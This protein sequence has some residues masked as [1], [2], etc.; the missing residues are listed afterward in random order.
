MCAADPTGRGI[1]QENDMSSSDEE[2]FEQ[3]G[4]A[5]HAAVSEAVRPWLV[6]EV[7]S[8]LGSADDELALLLEETAQDVERSIDELVGA[9][10]DQPLSGPL[11]RIRLCVEP[12]NSELDRRGVEPPA[13]NTVDRQLRPLDRHELGPMTFRDLSDGVHDAGINWGAAKAHLHLKRRRST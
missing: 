5:L 9:D 6:R 7:S 1:S 11:E 4:R 10:V 2:K 3:Y 8:R 13:R 12:L